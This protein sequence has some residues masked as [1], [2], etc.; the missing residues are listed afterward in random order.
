MKLSVMFQAYLFHFNILRIQGKNLWEGYAQG[1]LNFSEPTEF[2]PPCWHVCMYVHSHFSSQVWNS[3]ACT[4]YPMQR[5]PKAVCAV[6]WQP[7]VHDWSESIKQ[8]SL[9]YFVTG[10]LKISSHGLGCRTEHEKASYYVNK[11]SFPPLNHSIHMI[12]KVSSSNSESQLPSS[13]HKVC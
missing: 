9:S 2:R 8:S 13:L 12:S 3:R 1:T 10:A 5:T 4:A 6:H 11:E 7:H